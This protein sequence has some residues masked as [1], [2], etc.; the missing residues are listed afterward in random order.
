M[1]TFKS[2]QTMADYLQSVQWAVRPVTA[3][4]ARASLGPELPVE[5]GPVQ[6]WEVRRAAQSMRNS[7]ACGDD[8]IPSEFW[9]ALFEEQGPAST[10]LV[11]F[12]QLCWSSKEVPDGWHLARVA[13]IFK[14]GD[15]GDCANYRPISLLNIAYNIFA[16]LLLHRLR[17][18]GADGR[19]WPTQLGFK[20]ACGT[21]EALLIARRHIEKAWALQGGSCL[22]LALD[23]AKAFDSIDPSGLIRALQRFGLPADF[24]SMVQ[25][26]YTNRRFSGEGLRLQL[27]MVLSKFR[28]LSRLPAVPF[29]I[30]HFNYRAHDRRKGS[31]QRTTW[32]V[33][34]L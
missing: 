24:I 4:P 17:E 25:A 22:L 31:A 13:T 2:P 18:A 15:P 5:T 27:Y 12:C 10:W 16:N 6:A 8:S 3:V 29:S 9:R 21:D 14:K 26:I 20:Q 7:R 19:I 32:R 34:S 1:R 28:H 33:N 30:C 11:E 23:W